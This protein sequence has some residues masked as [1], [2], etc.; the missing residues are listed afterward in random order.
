MIDAAVESN[1]QNCNN[2]RK[3]I[4]NFATVVTVD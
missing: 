2:P 1:A 3:G 4:F